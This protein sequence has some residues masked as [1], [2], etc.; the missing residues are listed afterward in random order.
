VSPPD[1]KACDDQS[2]RV[3]RTKCDVT[4][5]CLLG[6]FLVVGCKTPA[7]CE[8]PGQ[9]TAPVL[10][11]GLQVKPMPAKAGEP[12]RFLGNYDLIC[13]ERHE[14]PT[15]CA[16]NILLPL[17]PVEPVAR[18]PLE[19]YPRDYSELPIAIRDFRPREVVVKSHGPRFIFEDDGTARTWGPVK[20]APTVLMVND[21]EEVG[22]S[23]AIAN[24]RQNCVVSLDGEVWCWFSELCEREVGGYDR[25]PYSRV[26]G[27]TR[28]IAVDVGLRIA[29]ALDETGHVYCWGYV[30]GKDDCRGQDARVV[31][32][33]DDA[34]QFVTGGDTACALTAGG[35]V[36]CWGSNLGAELALPR[37]KIDFS[38]EPITVP[39]ASPI[40]KLRAEGC[41]VI[42]LT[43]DG[44]VW[45]WGLCLTDEREDADPRRAEGIER[46]IDI[47]A[48]NSFGCAL[49]AD[50]SIRCF[51]SR[52]DD[53]PPDTPRPAFEDKA[54][55]VNAPL[56]ELTTMDEDE[57]R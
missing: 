27:I 15:A 32:G 52:V 47:V 3:G 44:E 16:G 39:V 14:A 28:A 4:R 24:G 11:Q 41:G 7:R 26:P 35:D 19:E 29:C 53:R 6:F 50:R 30:D 5:R 17:K 9:E 10:Q 1:A 13:A 18:N 55:W 57:P 20:G 42:A 46:A 54:T 25:L 33:I 23:K 38:I 21:T 8:A 36:R 37:S 40:V 45:Y 34:V 48:G 49:L 56:F 2:M 22:P 43:T 12:T 31:P 51:G